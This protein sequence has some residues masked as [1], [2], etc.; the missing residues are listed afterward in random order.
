MCTKRRAQ[1]G[2]T[3]IEVLVVIAI[4]GILA[5]LLLP[6]LGRVREAANRATC[7]SNLKQIGIAF[8]MYAGENHGKFPQR[9]VWNVHRKLSDTM[10]FHGP[11]MSPGYLDDLRVVWCPSW[12]GS[13]MPTPLARYDEGVR[14]NGTPVGNFNGRIDPE[15]LL[16]SPYNYT[17]WLFLKTEN[18]LGPKSGTLGSG[19]GGRFEETDYKDTPLGELAEANVA[20]GGAASDWDFRVSSKFSGTQA[21][22]GD[23][24]YRLREGVGRFLVTDVNNP[25]S[26]EGA[27]TMIPVMWDHLTPQVIGSCHVPAGMNVLYLDGHVQWSSYPSDKPWVATVEGPRVMG[28]Y[29]RPF[30]GYPKS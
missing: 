29:D 2:L 14:A 30:N 15:E 10:I 16:K 7:A 1:S 24:I 18:F 28:R 3:L 11:A 27:E 13:T 12:V 9:Q 20:S 4:I 17:G 25:A 23:I 22:G 26:R 6:T 21:G 5:A 8:K 19:P